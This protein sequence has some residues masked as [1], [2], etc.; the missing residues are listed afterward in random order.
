MNPAKPLKVAILHDYLNQFGG[1]E[2]VLQALLE[3]FPKAHIYTLIYDKKKTFGIFNDNVKKTSFLNN[4]LV[5]KRHRIFIPFMPLAA[6]FLRSDETY[7]LVISSSAGY[8][9]GI[10]VSAPYHISYCHTPLRYAWEID[11]LK[12][13][14]FSP[15]PLKEVIVRPIAKALRAWDKRSS[16]NVNVFFANS[17]YIKNKIRSYYG[18]DSEVIYP[19]VDHDVFY[20][21]RNREKKESY[22]IMAGRLLYYKR[23]DLGIHAF[24]KMKKKLKIVGRGPELQKLKRI[25]NSPHIEFIEVADDDTLR[26][27]YSDAEAFIFPQIEDFGL[28]AA[29]AESCGTPVLAFNLGGGSEI[30]THKKTGLLFNEQTPEA[31]ID[32]VK[33][34]ERIHWDRGYIAKRARAFSKEEFKR[35]MRMNI[36]KLGFLI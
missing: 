11:Y 23:F 31:I 3:I 2:R 1:A 32:V 25:A 24:N 14:P 34:A 26:S 10:H 5:Q 9:K 15:W 8:G 7:D 16:R 20:P 4:R 17:R 12:D 13:L 29:E 28:V 36:Q 35:R 27:L 6:Y 22:Y 30:V 18:R 19:P 21:E 33:E